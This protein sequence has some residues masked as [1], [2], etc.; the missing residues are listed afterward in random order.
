MARL[1]DVVASKI[2]LFNAGGGGRVCSL[3]T[4]AYSSAINLTPL[5]SHDGEIPAVSLTQTGLRNDDTSLLVI[6]F[7]LLCQTELPLY[8]LV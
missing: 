1:Y 2:H 5:L 4:H 7:A 6:V 3:A 8:Q